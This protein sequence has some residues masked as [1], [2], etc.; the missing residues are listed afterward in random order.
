M[1][2]FGQLFVPL[3]NKFNAFATSQCE[4]TEDMPIVAKKWDN[5]WDL[6]QNKGSQAV[7]QIVLI[8]HGQY[9]QGV[10]GDENKVLTPLGRTFEFYLPVAL[11]VL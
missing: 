4:P 6:R 3:R 9:Q 8:R 11:C 2:N 7:R 5:N 1:F 10:K